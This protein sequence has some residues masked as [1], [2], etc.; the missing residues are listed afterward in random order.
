MS[1]G[2]SQ[3]TQDFLKHCANRAVLVNEHFLCLVRRTHGETLHFIWTIIPWSSRTEFQFWN[4]FV[5][6]VLPGD[7]Q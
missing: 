6:N 4:C 5:H 1:L 7:L 2:F 3:F